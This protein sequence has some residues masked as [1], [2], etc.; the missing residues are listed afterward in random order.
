VKR[1]SLQHSG[2][3]DSDPTQRFASPIEASL[4][5]TGILATV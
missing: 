3:I 1:A 4:F 2:T 5:I